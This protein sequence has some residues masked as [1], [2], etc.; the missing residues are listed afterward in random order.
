MDR[1]SISRQRAE[2]IRRREYEAASALEQSFLRAHPDDVFFHRKAARTFG[3]LGDW[4]KSIQHQLR[5]IELSAERSELVAELAK[6]YTFCGRVDDAAAANAEAE[7]LRKQD[8][9]AL[10]E[11]VAAA[12]IMASR[13]VTAALTAALPEWDHALLRDPELRFA[14]AFEKHIVDS[15]SDWRRACPEPHER[16]TL[17]DLDM[18]GKFIV[19]APDQ[20][21]HKRLS[22]GIPW[23]LP[24]AVLLM[25]LASR[26]NPRSLII[27]VGANIGTITVPVARVTR[28][29]VLAYEPASVNFRD[30]QAHI[31]L[32][33][34]TNAL[35]FQIACS[36]RE[37]WGKM[38]NISDRNPGLAQLE[39]DQGGPVRVSTLDRLVDGRSVGLIKLDV[40][41][42]EP[43]VIAGATE[44]IKRSRPLILCEVR[45]R[46]AENLVPV[47]TEIGYAGHRVFRSDWLFVPEH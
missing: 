15:V 22:R 7:I 13:R 24:V 4:P 42:H 28:A 45:Q 44:T 8:E 3:A 26:I 12:R 36:D 14:A 25:E 29:T 5:A 6:L 20:V 40:E 10:A 23:E 1:N 41:G 17:V 19:G 43:K 16:G 18:I 31:H 21:I 9:R 27:E 30:L 38:T 37:G 32:N 11:R 35:P 39:T 33:S 47:F 2:L 34:L 46:D